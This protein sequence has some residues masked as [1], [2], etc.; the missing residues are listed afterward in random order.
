ML[1]YIYN[2]KR[3]RDSQF[4]VLSP[5]SAEWTVS[6]AHYSVR[7]RESEKPFVLEVRMTL[8]LQKNEAELDNSL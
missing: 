1:Q 7:T 3:K 8:A 6:S 2:I 5:K 4:F